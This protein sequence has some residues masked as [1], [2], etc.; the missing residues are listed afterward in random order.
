MQKGDAI[1]LFKTGQHIALIRQGYCGK[2]SI[3]CGLLNIIYKGS[4]VM[5]GWAKFAR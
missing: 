1:N 2:S 3:N 5:V 4:F